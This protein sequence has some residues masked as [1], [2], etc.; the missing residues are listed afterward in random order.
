MLTNRDTQHRGSSNQTDNY[1]GLAMKCCVCMER[2][3]L[4][5]IASAPGSHPLKRSPPSFHRPPAACCHR[6]GAGAP[7]PDHCMASGWRHSEC[8]L[9][10]AASE[11]PCMAPFS[12]HAMS[13][14]QHQG[15]LLQKA[16]SADLVDNAVMLFLL[17][18]NSTNRPYLPHGEA[19][20]CKLSLSC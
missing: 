18:C 4:S 5:R 12:L 1:P 2:Q 19:V 3:Q 8:R 13:R 7:S 17:C 20:N 10:P 11:G 15:W 9:Q 16:K 6:S 14:W